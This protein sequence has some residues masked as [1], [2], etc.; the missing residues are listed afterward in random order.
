[1]KLLTVIVVIVSIILRETEGLKVMELMAPYRI[2]NIGNSRF[3]TTI[4]QGIIGLR[5]GIVTTAPYEG[6][7]ATQQQWTLAWDPS[8]DDKHDGY[9]IESR[10]EYL[11]EVTA[12]YPDGR[13][14]AMPKIWEIIELPDE[15]KILKNKRTQKCLQVFASKIEVVERTCSFK[16]RFQHWRLER[17]NLDKR[18]NETI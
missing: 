15:I 3:L 1:M 6:R 18:I 16:N 12:Y 9:R 10:K 7:D 5:T 11:N 13:T 8:M 4:E 14:I 17:L 2:R